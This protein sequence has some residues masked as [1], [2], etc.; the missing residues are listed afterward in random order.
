MKR[1][2]LHILNYRKKTSN[3]LI[4]FVDY[5]NGLRLGQEQTWVCMA[6]DAGSFYYAKNKL[7]ACR[8]D[9]HSWGEPKSRT[10]AAIINK[11]YGY[12]KAPK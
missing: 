10:G 5:T 11:I 3:Y 6:W 12:M 1:N 2:S 9:D 8:F 7:S 4:N